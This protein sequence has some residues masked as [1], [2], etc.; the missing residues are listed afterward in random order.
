VIKLN[1]FYSQQP[2][3]RLF[4]DMVLYRIPFKASVCEVVSTPLVSYYGIHQV[5]AEMLLSVCEI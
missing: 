2:Q 3:F 1:L 5:L 4:E